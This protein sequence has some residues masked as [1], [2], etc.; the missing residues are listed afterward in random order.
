MRFTSSLKQ[1]AVNLVQ[2]LQNAVNAHD[3]ET[4]LGFYAENAV[5]VSPVYGEPSKRAAIRDSWE[6]LFRLFADW[7]VNVSAE[8]TGEACLDVTEYR[9]NFEFLL[10]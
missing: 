9:R 7:K 4:L 2:R 10:P 8:I 1:D 5:T 3:V 6:M